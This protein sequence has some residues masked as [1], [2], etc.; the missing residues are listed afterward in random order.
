M[1]LQIRR[2]H[3][4]QYDIS[5][6]TH[7]D[8]CCIFIC[9]CCCFGE[10]VFPFSSFYYYFLWGG[11]RG[12]FQMYNTMDRKWISCG[13][14]CI[15]LQIYWWFCAL[16]LP[17]LTSAFLSFFYFIYYPAPPPVHSVWVHCRHRWSTRFSGGPPHSRSFLS[18]WT[19]LFSSLNCSFSLGAVY[20]YVCVYSMTGKKEG[21]RVVCLTWTV[22][23]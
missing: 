16:I 12:C 9:C 8:L 15:C 23:C 18:N 14:Y 7:R 3:N 1:F 2:K 5:H 4:K 11:L 20:V 19:N 6:F 10:G 22:S 13:L 17:T 21:G